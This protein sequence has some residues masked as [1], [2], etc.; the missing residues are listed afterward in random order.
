M[1]GRLFLLCGIFAL[2][3]GCQSAPSAGTGPIASVTPRHMET[4]Q[5]QYVGEFF[6]GREVA[7]NRILVRSQPEERTGQYLVVTLSERAAQ[8]PASTRARLEMIR[9]DSTEVRVHDF[10]IPRDPASAR[11]IYLGLTGS[12]WPGADLRPVAWRLRFFD[13]ERVIAEWP[14][15]LWEGP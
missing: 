9:S 6:T 10:L 11:E 3:A 5:F 1:D 8:L 14:S 13:G 4:A 12:D 7:D 15:F 2:S